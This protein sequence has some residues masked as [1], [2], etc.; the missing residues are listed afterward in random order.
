MKGK[1]SPENLLIEIIKL[2]PIE[3]LGVCKIIGVSVYEEDVEGAQANE[4]GDV[5]KAPRDFVEIW[6]DV[7]DVIGDMNRVR[8]RNLGK[9]VHAATKKEK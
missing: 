5:T 6:Q 2:N 1:N 3:F 9:L 8:R 4:D 7:C